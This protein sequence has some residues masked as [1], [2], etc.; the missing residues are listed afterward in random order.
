MYR[1]SLFFCRGIQMS[2]NIYPRCRFKVLK[3]K[4]VNSGEIIYLYTIVLKDVETDLVLA[5]TE[6]ADYVLYKVPRD[7]S[8]Y[9]SGEGD[10]YGVCDFLNYL[11]FD[12]KLVRR[13]GETTIKMAEAYI[14]CYASGG[15][16]EDGRIPERATIFFRRRAFSAFLE[17]LAHYGFMDHI[18][19]G[20][21]VTRNEY[22]LPGSEEIRTRYS[23]KLPVRY[24]TRPTGEIQQLM[25]DLPLEIAQRFIDMAQVHDPEL[26]FAIVLMMYVGLRGGDVCNIYRGIKD[27]HK[28]ILT[29][30]I[31]YTGADGSEQHKAESIEICL[32]HEYALRSDGKRQGEIKCERIQPVF[33]PFLETIMHFYNYHMRLIKDKPCETIDGIRPMFLSK[34]KDAKTGVYMAMTISGLRDR[35]NSLYQKHVLP[36]CKND[37]NPNLARYYLQMQQGHTWGKH[38]FRH[39]YTVLLLY[40]GVDDANMLKVLRGDGSIK[41]AQTYI[42]NKGVLL[43]QY[44]QVLQHIGDMILPKE[45]TG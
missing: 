29:T 5:M 42:R 20:D 11:F 13:I 32:L 21:L 10:V 31:S 30:T 35:I 23:Y 24:R 22:R 43:D 44:K 4:Y 2:E 14:N 1:R 17:T 6:Y 28:G 27:K 38:A 15:R 12:E 8:I 34:N 36:S 40:C 25:R 18:F 16:S 26:V 45:V 3:T 39:Y 9:A 7:I 37:P 19:V 33:E 41:S